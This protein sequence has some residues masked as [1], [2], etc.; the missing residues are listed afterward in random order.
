MADRRIM[1]LIFISG[2][3]AVLLGAFGA[4]AL[5]PY[6]D[7]AGTQTFN[8]ANR[9]HFYHTFLAALL[10]VWKPGDRLARYGQVLALAGI[11]LFSGSLYL[12]AFKTVPGVPSWLGPITPMGGL[13]FILAWSTGILKLIKN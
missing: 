4:H 11:V 5:S 2:A 3:L 7:E 12:L 13:A 9:Y 8:T 6:L 1:M 10:G